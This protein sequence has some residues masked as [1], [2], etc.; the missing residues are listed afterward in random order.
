MAIITRPKTDSSHWYLLDG[1][2]FHTVPTAD[3]TDVRPTTVK[4]ARKFK[5][6]PSV[7]NVLNVIAKESLVTWKVN[8]AIITGLHNAKAAD[9]PEDTYCKR[10]SSMAMEQVFDAAD[11]GKAIHAGIESYLKNGTPPDKDVAEYVNPVIKLI[12]STPIKVHA[13]EKIL[14]NAEYGYAGTA[15]LLFKYGDD[16]LGC[17]VIDFKTRKSKPDEKMRSWDTEPLQLA[18]YAYTAWGKEQLP[19]CR[20]S[21]ILISTTEPGRVEV[22][23]HTEPERHFRA[24]LAALH[25]WRYMKNYTWEPANGNA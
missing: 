12:T 25:M 8:Q 17:G 5:A 14:V 19:T 13:L 1:S 22:V 6:V 24:F 9:E 20:I 4:D 7:T 3:G 10:I 23:K 2:P 21:N 11:L 18:A 16:G 15:D